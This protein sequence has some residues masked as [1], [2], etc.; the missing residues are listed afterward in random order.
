V[1]G[2]RLEILR[3]GGIPV[4]V[5]LSWIAV[6]ALVTW[7]LAERYFPAQAPGLSGQDF[8]LLGAAGCLGLFFSIVFHE[9]AHAVVA[10][11]HGIGIEGVTLFLFGGVAE[12]DSEAPGPR[13]DL[14]IAAAGPAFSLAMA[15]AWAAGVGPLAEFSGSIPLRALVGYLVVVNLALGLF[16]LLPAFPLDGG[17]IL[18]SAAWA[19]GLEFRR[20]TTLSSA[21]GVVLGLGVAASGVLLF[22]RNPGVHE[23]LW[24][25]LA[26]LFVAGAAG[27]S[28]RRPEPSRE[29]TGRP[30]CSLMNGA[31]ACIPSLLTVEGFL[32]RHECAGARQMFPVEDGGRLVG[33]V[34]PAAAR[35][36]QPR[37]RRL[38]S[39]SSLLEPITARNS[40][41]AGE[42]AAEALARMLRTGVESLLV[43]DRGRAVGT[44]SS[45]GLLERSSQ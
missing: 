39:V 19:F 30:V 17:R 28:R 34:R 18:R 14:M 10:R 42:D 32:S 15:G 41:M 45:R 44:F 26:G 35:A 20:A 13:A 5:D 33:L 43:I 11:R 24:V 22:L 1:F 21:G 2:V 16:N 3:I 38:R 7:S 23:A 12:L 40:V 37:E 31:P 36:L 25:A 6:A 9:L 4:R 29:V 8:W 27:A